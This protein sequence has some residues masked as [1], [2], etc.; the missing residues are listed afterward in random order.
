[1]HRHPDH[2][3]DLCAGHGKTSTTGDCH[4]GKDCLDAEATTTCQACD[5]CQ[6]LAHFSC[7][8]GGDLVQV[9]SPTTCSG[10]INSIIP[11][12]SSGGYWWCLTPVDTF[13]G[14]GFAVSAQTA[15]SGHIIVALETNLCDVFGF[16]GHVQSDEGAFLITKVPQRRARSQGIQWT[17][18]IPCHPR[19][20][21][22][23]QHWNASSKTN[24]KGF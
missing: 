7:R 3:L 4:K 11:L 5:S 23:L 14:Y 8:E 21:G 22:I 20:P 19:A 6:G 10:Q 24:Q 13:S 17:L 1:M 12:I 9:M 15:N 2:H 18:H 16:L